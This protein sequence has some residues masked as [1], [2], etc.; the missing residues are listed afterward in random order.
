MLRFA[1]PRGRRSR[2]AA[3]ARRAV[4]ARFARQG[5]RSPVR[6]G[7]RAGGIGGEKLSGRAAAGGGGTRMSRTLC[8]T[9]TCEALPMQLQEFRKRRLICQS[10]VQRCRLHAAAPWQWERMSCVENCTASGLK[11]LRDAGLSLRWRGVKTREFYPDPC[12]VAAYCGR[13]ILSKQSGWRHARQ[14]ASTAL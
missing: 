8:E 2:V 5:S 4:R 6:N 1:R 7:A 13:S 10:V 3:R 9:T 12:R 14:T 11:A